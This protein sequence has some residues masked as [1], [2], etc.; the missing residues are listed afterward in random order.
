MRCVD[1]S[2]WLPEKC[3]WSGLNEALSGQRED[4]GA[5]RDVDGDSLVTQPPLKVVE[6]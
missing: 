6:V 4:R 3:Y 2:V 5:L 1:L